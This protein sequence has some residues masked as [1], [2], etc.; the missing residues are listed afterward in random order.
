LL[1]A[2]D[3]YYAVLFVTAGVLSPSTAFLCWQDVDQHTTSTGQS[4][5]LLVVIDAWRLNNST[6]DR[7]VVHRIVASTLI[8]C[9]RGRASQRCSWPAGPCPVPWRAHRS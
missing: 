8:P 7:A 3:W 1:L 5:R 9:L 4:S 6:P 2:V